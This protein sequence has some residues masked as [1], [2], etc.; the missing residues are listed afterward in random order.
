MS[1]CGP[2]LSDAYYVR[3]TVFLRADGVHVTEVLVETTGG[4]PTLNGVAPDEIVDLA[5]SWS[6]GYWTE[7]TDFPSWYVPPS[8]SDGG[9]ALVWQDA[10]FVG[11]ETVVLDVDGA[12]RTLRHFPLAP[13]ALAADGALP[14]DL[15][16]QT[17]AFL[18]DGA[19]PLDPD[20]TVDVVDEDG[21]SHSVP[22]DGGTYTVE[23]D[24]LLVDFP[25]P[26]DLPGTPDHL[27]FWYPWGEND[28]DNFTLYDD[29]STPTFPL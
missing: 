6:E 29:W 18:S 1:A 17:V 9:A 5:G 27:L 23:G 8:H 13:K 2:A 20:G 19:A 12:T 21:L 15:S 16:G 22:L 10:P 26:L 14:A 3:F 25:D 11:D 24:R 4:E 7:G 28:G